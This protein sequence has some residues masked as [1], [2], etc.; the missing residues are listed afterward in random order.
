[1]TA[2]FAQV[3]TKP[4][5]GPPVEFRVRHRDSSWRH[6]EGFCNNLLHEPEVGGVVAVWRD[7]TGRVEAEEE[8][9]RLNDELERR[10]VERTAELEAA[11]A[12]LRESE[13]RF[14]K[15]FEGA[16]VGIA[17]VAPDGRWLRVNRKLCEIL[18]YAREELLAETFQSITH[19]DDR[20]ADLDNAR[21]LLEGEI[22]EYA[23]EK[24][25]L[26]KGGRYLW[27]KLSVSPV[28]EPSGEPS[29][30][31]SVVEDVD[32]RKR[33]EARLALAHGTRE[34][35]SRA[36]GAGPDEPADLGGSTRQRADRQVPRGERHRE[37]RGRRPPTG[38]PTR[39]RTRYRYPA[40]GAR[41][42][43]RVG[44]RPRC[45]RPAP[46][47]G[48]GRQPSRSWTRTRSAALRTEPRR[49]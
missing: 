6:I 43:P 3:L 31:I 46:E 41:T 49:S 21:R 24:R 14:R 27:A 34:G 17:H 7:V 18:G 48:R 11:V 2:G 36:S 8:V 23:M 26:T 12:G 25:Y 47:G 37:T 38:R 20:E 33:A 29:Y 16:A 45:T 22:S 35:G 4:G 10:V 9:R 5:V 28:R 1:M 42:R 19:P 15:T 40:I 39:R 13:E 30:L 32:E 44:R